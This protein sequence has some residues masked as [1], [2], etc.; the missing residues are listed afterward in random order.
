MNYQK[1]FL[2]L[3][4][5]FCFWSL[6][7]CTRAESCF[8]TLTNDWQDPAGIW[9][10]A[11]TQID[12]CNGERAPAWALTPGA[13][14][15]TRT[16]TPL[17]TW[18]ATRTN[19][20]TKTA[21]PTRTETPTITP[22]L[23]IGEKAEATLGAALTQVAVTQTVSAA[24]RNLASV[25]A[26]LTPIATPTSTPTPTAKPTDK[27]VTPTPEPTPTDQEKTYATITSNLPNILLV[28]FIGAFS[29]IIL[30]AFVIFLFKAGPHILHAVAEVLEWTWQ[31]AIAGII[32]ILVRNFITI[33]HVVIQGEAWVIAW[34]A[35]SLIFYLLALATHGGGEGG[36]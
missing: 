29:I 30:I 20:S 9:H 6:I 13:K 22:T 5:A 28:I 21:T 25:L 34:L 33:M 15:A 1:R 18:T 3:V 17:P 26:N 27:P 2:L 14:A 8:V 11:G 24:Q 23:T 36:H 7:A 32:V 35:L 19:T 12:P 10:R 31:L 16:P 4:F